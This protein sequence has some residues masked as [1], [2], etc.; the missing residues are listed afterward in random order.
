MEL[1][2]CFLIFRQSYDVSI[3]LSI[4]GTQLRSSNMLDLKNPFFRYTGQ[5]VVPPPGNTSSPSDTYWNQT[6]PTGRFE[7][8]LQVTS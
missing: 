3:E 4:P 1:M 7:N 5:A 8:M 2:H 6:D